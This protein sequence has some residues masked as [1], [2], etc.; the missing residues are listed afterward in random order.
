MSL[1]KNWNKKVKKM[2]WLDIGMIK[3]SVA[4]FI[5]MVAKLWTPLLSLD[6]YWYAIIFVLAM[7]RP[8]YKFFK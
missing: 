5:L 8:V 3:L 1:I 7:I 2:D 4:G 6:W